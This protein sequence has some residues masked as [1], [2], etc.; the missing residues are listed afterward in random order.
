MNITVKDVPEDLHSRLKEA[1][2]ET[3]RSLNKLILV[4]LEHSFTSKRTS[5]PAMIRR[6]RSRRDKMESILDDSTLQ[7]AIEGNRK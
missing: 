7:A 3:G 6:I 4:T 1:A 5:R 2:E